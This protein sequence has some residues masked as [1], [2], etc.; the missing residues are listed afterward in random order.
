M[1]VTV[2]VQD[3]SV[4][5]TTPTSADVRVTAPTPVVIEQAVTGPQGAAGPEGPA[6]GVILQESSVEPVPA[7][8][9]AIWIVLPPLQ[10]V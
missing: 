4:I 6:G 8:R 3:V 1:S 9:G 10:E 7:A 2:D 5:V